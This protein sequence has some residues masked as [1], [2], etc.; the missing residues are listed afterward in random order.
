LKRQAPPET[1]ILGFGGS[2]QHGKLESISAMPVYKDKSHEE[3]R[4]EDYQLGDKGGSLLFAHQSTGMGG[5][6]SS[7]TQTNAFS[8]SPTIFAQSST[9]PFF[10]PTPNSNNQ[11]ALKNLIFASGFGTSAP[12]FSSSSFSSSNT[13]SA[14]GDSSS[15]A[16]GASSTS[17][18]SSS[19]GTSIPFGSTTSAFGGQSSVFGPQTPTQAFVSRVA[20]YSATNEAN[21]GTSGQIGKLESISAMPFF[22]DKS[23]EELRWEDYQLGNKGST[24]AKWI[25]RL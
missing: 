1:H 24:L 7:T 16:F 17:K 15:P 5:F 10:S 3:L 13:S 11:S 6:N 12:A 22:K 25:F 8:P 18:S 23:H 2:G 4:W 9:N 14:F 19:F 20:S 21:S